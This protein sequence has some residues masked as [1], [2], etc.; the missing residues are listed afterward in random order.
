MRLHNNYVNGMEFCA[1]SI[2]L[3]YYFLY[4]AD[5]IFECNLLENLTII[6]NLINIKV[7]LTNWILGGQ[8]VLKV[9]QP[10]IEILIIGNMVRVV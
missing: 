10:L 3:L 5:S 7:I 1:F 8:K 4:G 9:H 6:L 2:Y